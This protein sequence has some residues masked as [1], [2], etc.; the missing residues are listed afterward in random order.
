MKVVYRRVKRKKEEP[1]IEAVYELRDS[2]RFAM[3]PSNIESTKR[4]IIRQAEGMLRKRE[5]R[6][7]KMGK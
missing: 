5:E 1:E 4:T 2:N 7:R 6:E 3:T